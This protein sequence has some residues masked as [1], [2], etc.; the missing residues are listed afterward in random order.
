MSGNDTSLQSAGFTLIELLV[1]LA[2][3]MLLLTVARPVISVAW[4]AQ[5]KRS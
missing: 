4:I 2:I 5:K 3:L 1:V